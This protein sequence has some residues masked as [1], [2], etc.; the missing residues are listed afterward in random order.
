M[1]R[2]PNIVVQEKVGQEGCCDTILSH[3]GLFK[4]VTYAVWQERM[5]RIDQKN[6]LITDPI[7]LYQD[8]E[9]S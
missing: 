7:D 3:K 4:T 2:V 5:Q 9:V 8:K 6:N 1:E